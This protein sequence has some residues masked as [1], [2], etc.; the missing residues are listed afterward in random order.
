MAAQAM[1]K[2]ELFR[3]ILSTLAFII[4]PC[5]KRVLMVHRTYRE[6]DENLGKYNG[7]GGKVEK[8]ESVTEGMKREIREE[9]GLEALSLSLRGTVLWQDFGPK[10]EDWLAFVFLVNGFRGVP[11]CKNEEGTLSWVDMDKIDSLP[12]WEG[13][14]LFLPMV[15]DSSP[16][17][18]HGYM[19]Y[20]GASPAEWRFDRI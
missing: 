6:D 18:F 15:F 8:G 12:M 10:K 17:V 3:P 20:E 16:K 4:S 11:K 19:R 5:K 2:K 1:G 7:I 14:R 13:D 9:T